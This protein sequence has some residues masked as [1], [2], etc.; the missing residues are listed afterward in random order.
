[1]TLRRLPPILVPTAL[2][3]AAALTTPVWAEPR[4]TPQQGAQPQPLNLSL[5]REAFAAP[6]TGEDG[7]PAQRNL[8]ATDPAA[9]APPPPNRLRYGAGYESRQQFGH[10]T[11]GSA[12]AAA[13]APGATGAGRRGR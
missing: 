6:P 11:A 5:P 10:G 7:P 4:R 12:P 3:L 9:A 1:M 8:R 13:G 2:A